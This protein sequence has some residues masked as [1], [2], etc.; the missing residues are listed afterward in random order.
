[1][2]EYRNLLTSKVSH[3]SVY[4]RFVLN[5]LRH[6]F[7]SKATLEVSIIQAIP[8]SLNCAYSSDRRPKSA[9]LSD[10]PLEGR[11]TAQ[12]SHDSVGAGERRLC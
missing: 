8:R 6:S 9:Y 1:M 2:S 4:K 5:N 11:R 12:L 3:K 7:R 10:M